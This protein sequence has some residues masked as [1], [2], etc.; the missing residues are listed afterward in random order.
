MYINVLSA[1]LLYISQNKRF[2]SLFRQNIP[3][4]AFLIRWP[5]N[6]CFDLS[7]LSPF[8]WLRKGN[9]SRATLRRSV[10]NTLLR[11]SA[12]SP[13]C[14]SRCSALTKQRSCAQLCPALSSCGGLVLFRFRAPKLLRME[15]EPKALSNGAN[16]EKV[17][18]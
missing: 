2:C 4:F 18:P 9:W 5:C 13:Q 11:P 6:L 3:M 7:T 17:L 14:D 12:A 8:D 15:L 1:R 10:S 16:V